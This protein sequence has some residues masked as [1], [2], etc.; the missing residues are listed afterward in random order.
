MGDD[1]LDLLHI[2][3]YRG[4]TTDVT[5]FIARDCAVDYVPLRGDLVRATD[6]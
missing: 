1:D 6:R 4:T 5:G 3:H 2:G